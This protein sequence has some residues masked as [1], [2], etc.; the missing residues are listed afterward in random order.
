MKKKSEKQFMD[1]ARIEAQ[2]YGA[3]LF[4]N[5]NGQATFVDERGNKRVV[6]YGLGTG[7]SDLI[8]WTP[9]K[10]TP[11]MMGQTLAVFTAMEGKRGS[12]KVSEDQYRFLAAVRAVGGIAGIFEEPEDVIVL[13]IKAEYGFEGRGTHTEVA[14]E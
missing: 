4:R 3:R 14:A 12:D 10:V 1:E 2:K 11:D 13:I 6:R 9:V 8:G 7:T 5:N